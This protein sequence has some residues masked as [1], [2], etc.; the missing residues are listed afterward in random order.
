MSGFMKLTF[1]FSDSRLH[2]GPCALARR[3]AEVSICDDGIARMS[4]NSPFPGRLDSRPR[5]IL[6]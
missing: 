4:D 1:S 3:P 5:P 6:A 2:Y